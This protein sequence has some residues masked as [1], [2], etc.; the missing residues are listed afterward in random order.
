MAWKSSIEMSWNTH[1]DRYLAP[2]L[3]SSEERKK[4]NDVREGEGWGR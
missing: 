3:D 1:A 2:R 4:V